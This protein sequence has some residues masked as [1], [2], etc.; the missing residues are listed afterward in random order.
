[1]SAV[2]I[3]FPIPAKKKKKKPLRRK[4]A[5]AKNIDFSRFLLELGS[6]SSFLYGNS[7]CNSCADHRVVSH[8]EILLFILLF[9]V[10]I[11]LSV[12]WN[13]L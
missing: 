10:F 4:D 1:V 3:S 13:Y 11:W 6:V 12:C 5:R 9:H 7:Y 8:A 2:C